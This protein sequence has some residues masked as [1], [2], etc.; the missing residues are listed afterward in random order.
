M[1]DLGGTPFARRADFWPM[2]GRAAL[3]GVLGAL[4]TLVFLGAEHWLHHLTWG[5]HE[6]TGEWSSGPLRAVPI[7]LV[8]GLGVGTGL[9]SLVAGASLGPEAPI[10]TAGAGIGTAVGERAARRAGASGVN[11]VDDDGG[12]DGLPPNRDRAVD[13]D[14]EVVADSA[15]AGM[16]GV[17]GGLMTFPFAVPLMALEMQRPERFDGY[18]RLLPGLVSA[19]VALAV[20]Y[21]IIG[22]P[23]LGLFDV[24]VAPLARWHFA[25]AV[26]LGLVGAAL[27]VLTAVVT[28]V[29]GALLERIGDVVVRAVLGGGVIA[30]MLVAVPL[31]GFSGREELP[32]VLSQGASLGVA[33]LV[34]AMLGKMLTFAVSMRAGFFGGAI[35]PLV[36]IGATGGVLVQQA[37]PALPLMHAVAAISAATAAALVPLPLSLM[38]LAIFMFATGVEAGAVPAVA[39]VTSYV[40]VH[41]TALL[42]TL[43]RL[44]AR[45]APDRDAAPPR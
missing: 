8:G 26:V 29:V 40:A 6:P 2:L 43:G 36:F 25:A 7:L 38:V 17:F 28:G 1:S 24:A 44:L 41:G 39:V 37:W 19:T 11:S 5:E 16:A 4:A 18:R 14:G 12:G 42:P 27:G 21:P 3:L 31:T 10:G 9:L 32:V 33:V 23:F 15:F 35:L 30:V 22:A 34:A 20:L 13:G 45:D